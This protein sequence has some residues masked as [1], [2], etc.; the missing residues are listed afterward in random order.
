MFAHLIE[1]FETASRTYAGDNG[2]VRDP[3]WFILKLQE[4]TGEVTQAWNRLTGRGRRKGLD[5]A[6]CRQ[7]L[8]DELAD[9]LG[10][11]FLL[12][13]QQDIDLPA[14]IARKWRFHPEAET[15]AGTR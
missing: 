10:H 11:V 15:R 1:R 5:E 7:A 9:L 6:A 14:A 2:I 4:E 3:D 8:A 12:A 13:G